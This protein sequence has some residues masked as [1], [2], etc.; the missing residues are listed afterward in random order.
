M[1]LMAIWYIMV[2]YEVMGRHG[3]A[4]TWNCTHTE[5]HPHGI[6]PIFLEM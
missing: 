6:A 1:C 5:M 3:I 2:Q 4:P